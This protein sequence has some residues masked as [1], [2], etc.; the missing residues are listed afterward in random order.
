MPAVWA[1]RADF[2]RAAGV[3]AVVLCTLPAACATT[4]PRVTAEA[5]P[6]LIVPEP[7]PRIILPPDPTPPPAP[8]ETPA[9]ASP[10]RARP[11][12]PPQPRP[13][14]QDP[15]RPAETAG[16]PRPPNGQEG[17]APA[18]APAEPADRGEG[19]VRRQLG[20]AQE[21][22]NRVDYAALSSTLRAQYDTAK[23]FITLGDQA[24]REQNVIYA[25]TLADKATTIAAQL[26][27]R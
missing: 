7:P 4:R 20:R 17:P 16:A 27:R 9:P 26:L 18:P 11:A 15:A 2:R 8:E 25:A 23:R 24:L 10:P 22:L 6:L 13:E 12:R 5:P 19:T 14:R 21:D 1:M 3:L